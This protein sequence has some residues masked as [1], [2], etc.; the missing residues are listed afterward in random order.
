MNDCNLMDDDVTLI[1][2]A[3]ENHKTW[4]SLSIDGNNIMVEGF[5]KIHEMLSKNHTIISMG[6]LRSIP[7]VRSVLEQMIELD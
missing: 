7:E 2:E 3:V 4:Q 5:R 6:N 1:C